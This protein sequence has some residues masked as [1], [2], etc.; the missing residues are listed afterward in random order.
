MQN[1][2]VNPSKDI[3]P[4]TSFPPCSSIPAGALTMLAPKDREQFKRFGWGPEVQPRHATIADAI[5]H[6][7]RHHPDA[8]AVECAGYQLSY[9]ALD[10]ASNRLANVLRAHGVK[11]GDAVCLFLH[12]S[13]E[14]VVGIVAAMKLGA[15]YVPQ[16]VG[17]APTE[18]M[19]H[20][21]K[22]TR[23]KV[24]LS[25][26][27]VADQVPVE[28]D[29]TLIRIDTV[30]FDP[31]L[32]SPAPNPHRYA[33]APDDLAMILFTSG[34]TGVPNGVKVTH[35]NLANILLTA[36][37]DL[38]MRPGLKVGQILSIAFDMAAWETL[39]ALAN[40]ATLVIRGKSIQETAEQVDVLIATP[41]ILNALDHSR[42]QQVRV[43]AVAGEPCPRPLADT[44]SSFSTFYNSCGPT[45][46]TIINTAEPHRPDK[47]TL[48]IGRPTPNN[49]VYVLDE[50]L[51]PLPIGQKGEMWAGGDC[52]TAG[53]LANPALTAERYRP[54]P[55]RPGHMMFRTRDLGRWTPT[56]ELE[57][58]GR[59][60]D[61]VKIRGFRVEL[62]SVTNALETSPCCQQ[63]VTLQYDSRN[64]VS[65]IS[66]A[67][68]CPKRAAQS[69]AD[70]LPYYCNPTVVMPMDTLP[71]TPRGKLDKRLLLELAQTHIAETGPEMH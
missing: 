5:R 19:R 18:T 15:A 6:S 17:V 68:A 66:P 42:C 16:H 3:H 57:H 32:D 23:A 61:M 43:A 9:R 69:V 1:F 45:E 26:S 60:D 37:G 46:T 71:R 50:N 7:L 44:W 24:L 10:D 62:D 64:L 13:I 38:G 11:R 67:S 2:A 20:V 28:P 41:S 55:F 34:T 8:I 21:A 35:G 40:G 31:M 58:F 14:M 49:T 39:G 25:L 29:Q 59:V 70:R 47:P 27:H 48:S 22:V 33:P 53:Y 54:D 56:G 30:M 63:A 52:V 12:R 65:F 4:L 51:Q 36:P